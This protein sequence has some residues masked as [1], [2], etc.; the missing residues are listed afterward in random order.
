MKATLLLPGKYTSLFCFSVFLSSS[1]ITDNS[2]ALLYGNS[3]A[4]VQECT[5]VMTCHVVRCEISYLFH[6]DTWSVG[7]SLF[8]LTV[9]MQ[10]CHET[11]NNKI[12]S[13][14]MLKHVLDIA[15][16]KFDM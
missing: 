8:A 7:L 12:A 10:S 4:S 5:N 16:L 13:T 1:S 2:I 15:K 14:S 6:P 9:I 11:I 3:I